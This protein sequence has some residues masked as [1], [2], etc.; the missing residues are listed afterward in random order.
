MIK[1]HKRKNPGSMRRTSR[2]YLNSVNPGKTQQIKDSIIVYIQAVNFFIEL[3]WSEKDLS[4]NLADKTITDKGVERFGITSRLAQCAAKQA[5]EVIRS[6]RK[7]SKNKQRMP[8]LRNRTVNLDSRFFSVDAFTGHFELCL[9]LSSGLPKLILPFNLTEHVNKFLRDSWSLSNSIRL[10]FDGGRLFI[11]L[12][13]EKPK[14]ELKKQG[15]V[16]GID[17][18]FNKI[19][20][21]SDGQIIGQE[22]KETILAQDKRSNTSHHFIETEVFRC[23][24]SLD[25]TDVKEIVLEDLSYIK[26]GRRGKFSRG[27]KRLLSFWLTARVV[28]WLGRNVKKQ[29]SVFDSYRLVLLHKDAVIAARSIREIAEERDSNAYIVDMKTMQI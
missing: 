4:S 27:M 9:K 18:G 26:H 7:L 28:Q 11:D 20:A 29:G 2:I 15:K 16:V 22:L 10:G 6:Q 12:I 14:P 19:L 24:K 17:R 1:A 23:L 25:L 21:C 5:K 13:F 8:V 3:F